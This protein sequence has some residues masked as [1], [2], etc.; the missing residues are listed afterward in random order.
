MV[1]GEDLPEEDKDLPY[2]PDFI[3]SVSYNNKYGYLILNVNKDMLK[4]G[5]V[6][7]ID[8][9]GIND[10]KYKYEDINKDKAHWYK[11]FIP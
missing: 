2:E 8:Y 4:E 3:E 6:N 1:H 11:I 9:I 10:K 5:F 7:G